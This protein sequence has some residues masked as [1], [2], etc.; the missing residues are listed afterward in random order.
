M[1]LTSVLQVALYLQDLLTS[2]IG[3]TRRFSGRVSHR[4]VSDDTGQLREAEDVQELREAVGE[5]THALR[6]MSF[7]S[8]SSPDGRFSQGMFDDCV[9]EIQ[10]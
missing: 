8:R 10:S 3:Q 9:S 4:E 6:E 1:V 5:L 2:L 7:G